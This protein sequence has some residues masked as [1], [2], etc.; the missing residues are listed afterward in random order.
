MA[1]TLKNLLAM[2]KTQVKSLCQED[3][4]EKGMAIH[5]SILAWRNP[6]TEE[7]GRL[8]SMGLQRVKHDWVTTLSHSKQIILH[9]YSY[10]VDVVISLDSIFQKLFIRFISFIFASKDILCL[11]FIMKS[12]SVCHSVMS[13]FATLMDCSQPGFSVHRIL[14]TRILKRVA[15]PFIIYNYFLPGCC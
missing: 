14:Q 3:P 4:L 10:L 15:I 1:Q 7:P 6:Q 5:S 12:V 11:I 13:D 2:W 9:L 8:Q